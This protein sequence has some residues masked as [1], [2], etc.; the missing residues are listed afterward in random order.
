[1]KGIF[2]PLSLV[3]LLAS[4]QTFGQITSKCSTVYDMVEKMPTY[5]NGANGLINYLNRDLL[6]I[7]GDCMKRDGLIASLHIVLTID[8]EGK[9]IDAT[10][11][12][13]DLTDQCKND[14]R[15]K[16]LTMTGWTAGQLDGRNVCTHFHWPISCLK[17]E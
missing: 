10:F 1:M 16:L 12:R 4:S 5:D 7:V 6:P 17:W 2:S 9:V 15:N 14:L 13:Q 8:E 11:P 3:I